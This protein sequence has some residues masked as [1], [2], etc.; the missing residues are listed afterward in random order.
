MV[1]LLKARETQAGVSNGRALEWDQ[2]N[3]HCNLISSDV[4]LCWLPWRTF[5]SAKAQSISLL[6]PMLETLRLSLNLNILSVA[7]DL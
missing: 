1:A 2:F 3:I 5:F 4:R 7:L 6:S